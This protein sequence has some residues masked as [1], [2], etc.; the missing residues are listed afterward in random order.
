MITKEQNLSVREFRMWI[1]SNE[2]ERLPA[3]TKNKLINKE[4]QKVEDLIKN[5]IIIKNTNN[6]EIMSEKILTK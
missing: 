2:F 3:E 5:P 6:Y 1:K 4:Q